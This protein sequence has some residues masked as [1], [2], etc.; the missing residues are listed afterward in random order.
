MPAFCFILPSAFAPAWLEGGFGVA[1]GRSHEGRMGVACGS[2]SVGYQQAL[3]WLWGGL[4]RLSA[5]SILPSAFPPG[6]LG[7]DFSVSA[8]QLF[9]F[10]LACL[11]NLSPV[12]LRRVSGESPVCLPSLARVFL[13]SV[14]PISAFPSAAF[15]PRGFARWSFLFG[16]SM[17]D[18]GRWKF[19]VRCSAF[20]ISI[21]NPTPLPRLPR[22]GLGAP[23]Y[24]PGTFLYP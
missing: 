13:L 6:W 1:L 5:F 14:F 18:V 21:L 12:C 16:C 11:P 19:E 4:M 3:G 10:C 9:S 8:F 23:W 7:P 15:A 17:L 20:T 22:G 2:Q 24:R